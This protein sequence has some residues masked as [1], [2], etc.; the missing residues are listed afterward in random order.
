MIQSKM[1]LNYATDTLK[2]NLLVYW[3]SA[4]KR[5][6]HGAGCSKPYQNEMKIKIVVQNISLRKSNKNDEYYLHE[7]II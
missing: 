7:M 6:N 4:V 5:K 3:L 2:R 1:K